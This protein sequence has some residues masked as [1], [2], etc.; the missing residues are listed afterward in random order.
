MPNFHCSK[1]GTLNLNAY[2]CACGHWQEG[3]LKATAIGFKNMLKTIILA[4]KVK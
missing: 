4:K 3:Y 2:K 1:C